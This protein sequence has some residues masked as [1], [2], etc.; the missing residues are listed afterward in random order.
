M[1]RIGKDSTCS[2]LTGHLR[3]SRMYFIVPVESRSSSSYL[4]QVCDRST[5]AHF[6]PLGH[7]L[8]NYSCTDL[9][10]HS[11]LTSF[12]FTD[13]GCRCFVSVIVIDGVSVNSQFTLRNT[14]SQDIWRLRLTITTISLEAEYIDL[15]TDCV[16]I[17]FFFTLNTLNDSFFSLPR[18]CLHRVREMSSKDGYILNGLC[19]VYKDET[20]YKSI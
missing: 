4:V 14:P 19:K 16:I 2:I 9:I 15:F 10:L 17:C 18:L 3:C 1:L 11:T 20:R 7:T 6:Q 5:G 8:F 13:F 12:N